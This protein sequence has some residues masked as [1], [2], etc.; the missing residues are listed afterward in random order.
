V[1]MVLSTDF[2]TMERAPG[3]VRAFTDSLTKDLATV[4]NV[5]KSSI[6]NMVASRSL[7]RLF[8]V[9]DIKV[10]FSVVGNATG[11]ADPILNNAKALLRNGTALAASL[12]Q[13]NSTWGKFVDPKSVTVVTQYH[14][15]DHSYK[16]DP[17]ACGSAHDSAK[18]SGG[19]IAGI[20][21]G[22][23]AFCV[24]LGLI[25]WYKM[26]SSRDTEAQMANKDVELRQQQETHST[27]QPQVVYQMPIQQQQQPV[28]VYRVQ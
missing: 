2:N 26:V 9:G 28:V 13:A 23:V 19:A 5:L 20:V 12:K 10:A 22:V 18:L 27:Q 8:A 24:I 15:A 17:N 6:A 25:V 1:S 4:L 16:T 7:V 14:C 11:S 21:I 3:G